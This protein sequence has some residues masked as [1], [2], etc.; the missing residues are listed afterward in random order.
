MNEFTLWKVT[1]VTKVQ[2]EPTFH[3]T[4]RK[5]GRSTVR[6]SRAILI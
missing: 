1:Q 5:H 3:N 6:V 4:A 2:P